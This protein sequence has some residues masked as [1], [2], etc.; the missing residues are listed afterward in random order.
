MKSLLGILKL[1]MLLVFSILFQANYAQIAVNKSSNCAP[2][3]VKFSNVRPGA[4]SF[5]WDFNNGTISTV[6]NPEIY[7][8]KTGITKIYSF[9]WDKAGI[10]YF[11][12]LVLDLKNGPK[13]EFTVSN[14]L[15]C[16]NVNITFSDNSTAGFSKIAKYF[17][18]FGNGNVDST[19]NTSQSYT[20][21]GSYDITYLVTDS[22]D[23]SSSINKPK[24]ISIHQP[25]N[26]KFNVVDDYHC[27]APHQVG[28]VDS[29]KGT[30]PLG[31]VWNFGN[32]STS[33]TKNP[34]YNYLLKGRY[35]VSLKVTD[36]NNCITDY[37]KYD[38]VIIDKLVL[39]F[40]STAQQF[41]VPS[42]VKFTNLSNPL[43]DSLTFT[44]K[45]GKQFY[46]GVNIT[47]FLKSGAYDVTL[48]GS[49]TGCSDSVTKK[50]YIFID[51]FPTGKIIATDSILC[52]LKTVKYYFSQKQYKSILWYVN[53]TFRS[54]ADTFAFLPTREDS[55]KIHA[56]YVSANDCRI[57]IEPQ[58]LYALPPNLGIAVQP[59]Q[60]VNQ[61]IKIIITNKSTF[62]FTEFYYYFND[63]FNTV[64]PSAIGNLTKNF[65][66]TGFFDLIY[67]A[68]DIHKCRDTFSTLIAPGMKSKPNKIGISDTSFCP[69]D[70]IFLSDLSTNVKIKPHT[71]EWIVGS[72]NNKNDNWLH[73]KD[74]VDSL[75]VRLVYY[76]Y[77][78]SDTFTA[79]NSIYVY[80]VFGSVAVNDSCTGNNEVPV[81]VFSNRANRFEIKYPDDII[82]V[83]LHPP[84]KPVPGS[85]L[86]QATFFN[87]TLGCEYKYDLQKTFYSLLD[88]ELLVTTDTLCAPANV[89]LEMVTNTSIAKATWKH[90]NSVFLEEFNPSVFIQNRNAVQSGKQLFDVTLQSVDGC[91]KTFKNS[92]S[93]FGPTAKPSAIFLDSCLPGN[94]ILKDDLYDNLYLRY[95]LAGADTIFQQS[96]S[97]NALLKSV[98][99][100]KSKPSIIYQVIDNNGCTYKQ[101]VPYG[102]TIFYADV[103]TEIFTTCTYPKYRLLLFTNS[104]TFA[105]I[106]Y[107]FDDSIVQTGSRYGNVQFNSG[108]KHK[109]YVEWEDAKGCKH[110]L[111]DYINVPAINLKAQFTALDSTL[112]CAPKLFQLLNKSKSAKGI[113][114]YEWTLS[115]GDRATTVNPQIYLQ[116][117]GSV[118]IC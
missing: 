94:V 5:F 14:I 55:F 44:W 16:P 32:G 20:A 91:R 109:Y 75:D 56:I 114:K 93:I 58:K 13:A 31:Y 73:L 69:L 100:T 35:N 2:A 6:S 34:T 9:T 96:K 24:H 27:T 61:D 26:I 23:C 21:G 115:N 47:P 101:V 90:N 68:E 8:P 74:L 57:N 48:Y 110:A 116:K 49:K 63:D 43:A 81:L 103:E 59:S 89:Q 28:F 1:L 78:C 30:A 98:N 41:C 86:F 71:K 72:K 64:Y 22:L 19:I 113:V 60:C 87:D 53:D 82:Y 108:G 51:S 70:T 54:S 77:G 79:Y 3:L 76:N 85:A 36:G 17:W 40:K 37:T 39:D 92:I 88:G 80:P 66:D 7:F 50:G 118:N 38:A 10:S 83:N 25:A 45:I 112:H 106:K 99:E 97:I 102:G 4:V 111:S 107:V 18:F 12:S 42:D 67:I 15:T 29:T 105:S 104:F 62:P 95:W 46:T 33:T 117:T 11:D 65:K 84:H 52:H